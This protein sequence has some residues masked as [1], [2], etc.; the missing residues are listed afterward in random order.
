M[1][2][3]RLPHSGLPSVPLKA[4]GDAMSYRIVPLSQGSAPWKDWRAEGVGGSD[5][6]AILGLEPG[7]RNTPTRAEIFAEK[8]YRTERPSNWA[9]RRGILA[10]SPARAGYLARTPCVCHAHCVEMVEVPWAHA[11]LDGL[12]Q[13]PTEPNWLV[14]IKAPNAGAHDLALEGIVPDY[15]LPQI[16]W[17]LLVTALGRCDYVSVTTAARFGPDERLAVVEVRADEA[18]QADILEEAARFWFSVEEARAARART[19]ATA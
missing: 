19:G 13:V 7:W 18:R 10:E 16:Q 11:S 4:P 15:Y 14:E 1:N 2:E 5:L 6:V 17:Q 12:C 8:V 3:T 9:M